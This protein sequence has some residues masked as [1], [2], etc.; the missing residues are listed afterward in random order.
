MTRVFEAVELI[1]TATEIADQ[2]ITFGQSPTE[3]ARRE[4]IYARIERAADR[5]NIHLHH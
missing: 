4:A 3:A 5:A 2:A 1:E